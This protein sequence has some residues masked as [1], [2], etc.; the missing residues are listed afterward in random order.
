MARPPRDPSN[1]NDGKKTEPFVIR[2]TD[3]VALDIY[4]RAS[5][6][7]IPPAVLLRKLVVAG[8][9]GVSRR[10][11]PDDYQSSSDFA[12]LQGMQSDSE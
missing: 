6:L 10:T 9:Y 5:E 7:D 4:R 2:V 11:A 3:A 12:P 1:P 8:M